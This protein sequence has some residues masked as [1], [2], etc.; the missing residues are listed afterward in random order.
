MTEGREA[1]RPAGIP[2]KSPV[3]PRDVE[4]RDV[5]GGE[6][7]VGGG[8]GVGVGGGVGEGMGAEKGIWTTMLLVKSSSG[9]GD[10]RVQRSAEGVGDLVRLP[11][12]V[13]DVAGELR[14]EQEVSLGSWR[15]SGTW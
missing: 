10:R 5:D 4:A 1:H 2:S 8:G 15:W 11:G 14:D 12:D 13:P 7:E 9:R 3:R 6:G